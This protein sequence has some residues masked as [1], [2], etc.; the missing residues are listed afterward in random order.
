MACGYT[1]IMHNNLAELIEIVTR[2][3]NEIFAFLIAIIYLVLQT[4]I[5][6]LAYII[7]Q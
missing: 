1:Y 2:F 7:A 3:T 4:H 5:S 6:A